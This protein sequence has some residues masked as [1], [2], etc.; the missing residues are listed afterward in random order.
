M[1]AFESIKY[2]LGIGRP[3]IGRLLLFEGLDMEFREV[4]LSRRASCPL[5]GDNPTVVGGRDIVT[6]YASAPPLTVI[7]PGW[8]MVCVW[9]VLE[10]A[11]DRDAPRA[12]RKSVCT[13]VKAEMT[14]PPSVTDVE[15]NACTTSRVFG[16]VPASGKFCTLVAT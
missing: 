3:L 5:C 6:P 4:K 8:A 2:I 9:V 10:P 13:P 14:S 15:R 11:S 16:S 7:G 1:M 12:C